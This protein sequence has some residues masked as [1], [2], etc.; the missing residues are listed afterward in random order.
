LD[1]YAGKT[2]KARIERVYPRLEWDSRTRIT[3]AKITE[4]VE[5]IP[6]LF[7]RMSVQGR[8]AD[9]AV[10]VPDAA[11][12]TTPR[13][14]KVVYVV[15]EGKAS[16]RKVTIGLEQGRRV[17][18]TDGVQTGEMVVIAANLN[19]KDGV[20]VQVGKAAATPATKETSGGNEQ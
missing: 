9:D 13:G 12:V 20:E 16:M 8:V 17:Q 15:K 19:L 6:R 7:A 11:L 1:A 2:F 10:V 18:I 4:P 5:L 3:E 14:Q